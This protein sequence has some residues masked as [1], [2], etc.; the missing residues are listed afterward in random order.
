MIWDVY[1][2]W[3]SNEERSNYNG[4]IWGFFLLEYSFFLDEFMWIYEGIWGYVFGV[5][6]GWVRDKGVGL[7]SCFVDYKYFLGLEIK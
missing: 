2:F 3:K 5:F 4:K 1:N 6:Y 7:V